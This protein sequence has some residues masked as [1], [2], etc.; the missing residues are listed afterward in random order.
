M[1]PAIG[2]LELSKLSKGYV[3]ADAVVKKAQVT[4]LLTKAVS[5]GK[6]LLLFHGDEEAVAEALQAGREAAD[7]TLVDETYIPNL[8]PQVLRALTS[9]VAPVPVDSLGLVEAYSAASGVRCADL[10]VKHTDVHLL[11]LRLAAGIGGK[12][13]L[14]F[15]GALHEVEASL[16]VCR[17][18]LETTGMLA[19]VELIAAPHED[20]VAALVKPEET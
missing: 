20:L 15:C 12:S 14:V 3:A 13:F 5:P 16:S 6:F 19:A 7:A 1:G 4:L 8:D 10:A 2:L 18:Y 17:E 9:P 11:T